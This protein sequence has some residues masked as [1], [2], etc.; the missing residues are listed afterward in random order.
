MSNLTTTFSKRLRAHTVTLPITPT[1][2][3]VFSKRLNI[4]AIKKRAADW[5]PTLPLAHLKS[6]SESNDDDDNGAVA[7]MVTYSAFDPG[8][9][10]PLLLS[11]ALPVWRSSLAGTVSTSRQAVETQLDAPVPAVGKLK[12]WPY[13]LPRML[14]PRVGTTYGLSYGDGVGGKVGDV[15]VGVLQRV[16]YGV[17]EPDV[18]VGRNQGGERGLW[19]KMVHGVQAW[20]EEKEGKA[21][22]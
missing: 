2:S 11:S 17:P 22:C 4:A 18:V 16:L 13:S 5:E 19:R 6:T 3:T 12:P 1:Q 15:K 7:H 8:A 21:G 9:T 20:E 14:Q 10:H